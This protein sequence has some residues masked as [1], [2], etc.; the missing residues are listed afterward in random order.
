MVGCFI[1]LISMS[2]HPSNNTI[3]GGGVSILTNSSE[4]FCIIQLFSIL[5]ED[6]AYVWGAGDGC[7]GLE[8]FCFLFCF[9]F[10]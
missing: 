5:W 10:F 9:L 1:V 2:V 3:L 4:S 8:S 7:T 6:M